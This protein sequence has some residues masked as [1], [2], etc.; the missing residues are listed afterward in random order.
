MQYAHDA[1]ITMVIHQPA[2]EEE[3]LVKPQSGRTPE[4]KCNPCAPRHPRGTSRLLSWATHTLVH[5]GC[6]RE[7]HVQ[8]VCAAIC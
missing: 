5:H 4:H 8:Q 7:A 6:S 1:R 3:G 2:K